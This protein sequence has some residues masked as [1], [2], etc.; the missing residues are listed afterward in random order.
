[1]FF[2]N[3]SPCITSQEVKKKKVFRYQG[4]KNI[5]HIDRKR[6]GRFI[7]NSLFWGETTVKNTKL[8]WRLIYRRKLYILGGDY[9]NYRI[10]K[11]FMYVSYIYLFSNQLKYDYHWTYPRLK[12]VFPYSLRHVYDFLTYS[13]ASCRISHGHVTP[14][15]RPRHMIKL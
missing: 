12:Q 8:R 11:V 10:H 4:Q 5:G 2:I 14:F 9:C 15:S 1:M 6:V 13:D 7:E 3:Q